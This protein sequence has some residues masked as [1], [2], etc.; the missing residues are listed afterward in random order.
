MLIL[1]RY[2]K[3]ALVIECGGVSFEIIVVSN[4]DGRVKL[5]FDAPRSVMITRKE[6][7]GT[8]R[9]VP[10]DHPDYRPRCMGDQ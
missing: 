8:G 3:Q 10:R 2:P 9:D 5:A 1:T 7:I 6:L 4:V